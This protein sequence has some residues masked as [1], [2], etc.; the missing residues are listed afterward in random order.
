MNIWQQNNFKKLIIIAIIQAITFMPVFAIDLDY[1][2]DDAIRKNYK[3]EQGPNTNPVVTPVPKTVTPTSV[4]QPKKSSSESMPKLP[5][6]PKT[7]TQAKPTQAKPVQTVNKTTVKQPIQ[8]ISR[9]AIARTTQQTYTCIPL[10]KGTEIEI[11]NINAISDKQKVG[12]NIVFVSDKPV[13][14]PYYTIPQGTKFVGKIVESHNPQITGNGGLVSIE[15]V[16]IILA[17]Q[18]QHIDT[19]ITKINDKRIFFE[20]IKGKHSYWKNTVNK[21]KWG[22]NTYKKMKKLSSNLAK[23]KTT[24]ILSPFTFVYGVALGGISTVSSPVVSIFCKGGSVN[25]PVGTKF[26]IKFEK[27]AK[28]R[29]SN[30]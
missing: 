16:T 17:N 28:V 25:L 29:V 26:V 2:V 10:R 23:D 6:L 19:R 24:V 22:R 4:Q 15:V 12:T 3:V 11:S 30:S 5:A 20:D 8:N 9:S 14:T 1:T 7:M 13:R 21:G 27:D 18:Y